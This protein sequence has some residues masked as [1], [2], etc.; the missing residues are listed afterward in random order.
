MGSAQPIGTDSAQARLQ[1]QH[2]LLGLAVWVC[3]G[4]PLM[5]TPRQIRPRA[6]F[7][8]HLRSPLHFGPWS[9]GEQ[10]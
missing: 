4:A 2:S 8:A 10:R 1:L 5:D 3:K 9:P 6:S 7:A